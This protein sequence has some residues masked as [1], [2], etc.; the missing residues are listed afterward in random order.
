MIGM[1][2]LTVFWAKSMQRENSPV[3]ENFRRHMKVKKSDEDGS[4]L[5]RTNTKN[6]LGGE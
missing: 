2:L 1:C 4:Q 6:D 5:S 3:E